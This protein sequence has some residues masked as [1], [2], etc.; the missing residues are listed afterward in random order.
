VPELS[1]FDFELQ[2]EGEGGKYRTRVLDSPAGQAMHKFEQPFTDQELEIFYLRVGRPR[3]GTRRLDSPEMETAKQYGSRLFEDIFGEEVYACFRSSLAIAQKDG[4]GLRIRLRVNSPELVDLPWE[5]LYNPRL[6]NFLSLSVETPIVRYFELAQ[7]VPILTV[8]PPIKVLVMISSPSDYPS[9]D[10]DTEWRR[11]RAA[12]HPLEERGLVILE[13]LEQATLAVL[14]RSL[15][16]GEYH[17]FH[18]IGHGHFDERAQDG[19]LLF[20][21]EKGRGRSLSGLYLGTLL[22]NHRSLRLAVLNACEGARTS[23]SDP[24][25]GVAHSLLKKDI[26]AVIAMQ[27]EIT[28]KAAV[29]FAWE[30][31]ASLADGYPVDAALAEAR[32]AIFAQENDIEWGNPVLFTRTLDGR[33]FNIEKLPGVQPAKDIT[34]PEDDPV[35]EKRLEELYDNGLSAYW[36]KDWERARQSFRDLL[37]IRPD[38]QD[39][40]EK[41]A[42]AERQINLAEQYE[43]VQEK[44]AA[45]DWK[46]VLGVLEP[47]VE[48][49]PDYLDVT[50]LLGEVHKR[51]RLDDLYD[52]VKRLVQVKQWQA[53]LNVFKLIDEIEPG[54]DP[55]QLLPTARSALDEQ[56][57]ETTVS[58]LYQRA[59]REMD[60]GHWVEAHRLFQEVQA[61]EIGYRDTEQMLEQVNAEL[62]RQETDEGQ[63]TITWFQKLPIWTKACGGLVV[64]VGG[65]V[66]II[67]I[68]II[69]K[70]LIPSTATTTESPRVI[71]PL[72]HTP[73]PVL[74]ETP[75][76]P[77]RTHTPDPLRTPTSTVTTNPFAPPAI[78]SIGDTWTSPIDSMTMVY[79]PE[80]EF[81]MGSTEN[82]PQAADNE[83]PHRTVYLDAFWID[84]T[85]VTNA[86]Y[87]AF[88]NDQGNQSE[89]GAAWF[90]AANEDVLIIQSGGQW[91]PVEGYSDHPAVRVTWYGARAYC[92]M[93]GRR[94]PSEAEWEKAARGTDGRIY[95]W[96]NVFDCRKGNFDDETTV[97]EY[98][99][100]GGA[101]C[102]GY[103]RSAPVGSYPGGASPY[104]ALDMAGNVA[105]WVADWYD[106]DYYANSPNENPQG[107]ATGEYCVLRGGCWVLHEIS[108][109][110]AYRDRASPNESWRFNGFR[111]VLSP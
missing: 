1:Y 50:I 109:R 33:I 16:R 66:A 73:S 77:T 103:D 90:D 102:D 68:F 108:L 89:G 55:E 24:F 98:V 101:G 14:Q 106:P 19:Q 79:I 87:A 100:P 70:N 107:P 23:R 52:E 22:H 38:Y 51:I 40:T 84:H 27:S 61:I 69:V 2:F 85:E 17:I 104:G 11:L 13:C 83:K 76:P 3:S 93:V 97:D 47:L 71:A 7:P 53:V 25:A 48:A 8:K 39:A 15:R 96:G 86:M 54:Y 80:G 81:L 46:G 63:A 64:L 6:D 12:L 67:L 91:V 78:A 4:K 49:A 65:L 74:T 29:T 57:P 35:L 28:N 26:P 21:D 95:P 60:I 37:Y 105:E 10:V 42:E 45:Q 94:L 31:Y 58:D 30:F 20:E 110:T 5:Y 9:L 18:F 34:A 62:A 88:L 92:E 32:V 72:T 41:L 36:L 43:Q 82:D 59:V 75:L 111:C 44:M 56:E 99:V